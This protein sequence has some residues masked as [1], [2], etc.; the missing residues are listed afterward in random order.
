MFDYSY[1]PE[2]RTSRLNLRQFSP[3]D[4]DSFFAIRSDYEVTKYNS[5]PAYT[6]RAQAVGLIEKTLAGFAKRSSIYWAIT[7]TGNDIV[8]GQLGFN[9]WDP[10]NNLAEIGTYRIANNHNC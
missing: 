4:A 8:I 7:F 2:L 3:D 6:D 10:D 5:G 9:M 1:F